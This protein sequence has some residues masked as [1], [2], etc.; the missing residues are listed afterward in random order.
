MTSTVLWC[1]RHDAEKTMR[2]AAPTPKPV[3]AMAPDAGDDTAGNVRY[4]R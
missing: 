4:L 2:F 3:A 1:W